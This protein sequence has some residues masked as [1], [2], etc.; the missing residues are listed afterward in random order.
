VLA[1]ASTGAEEY[2]ATGPGSTIS[3]LEAARDRLKKEAPGATK[4]LGKLDKRI[5]DE[6]A[7]S[8]PQPAR[9]PS[10]STPPAKKPEARPADQAVAAIV[11]NREGSLAVALGMQKASKVSDENVKGE[12]DRLL[13]G[14]NLSS[15]DLLKKFYIEEHLRYPNLDSKVLRQRARKNAELQRARMEVASKHISRLEAEENASEYGATAPQSEAEKARLTQAR[16]AFKKEFGDAQKSR[17]KKEPVE[18]KEATSSKVTAPAAE[19]IERARKILRSPEVTPLNQPLHGELQDQASIDAAHPQARDLMLTRLDQQ[20]EN[21]R[22]ARADRVAYAGKASSDGEVAR[23]NAEIADLRAFRSTSLAKAVADR[24]S[25]QQLEKELTAVKT[26]SERDP[27]ILS[28]LDP[29]I[30]GVLKSSYSSETPPYARGLGVLANMTADEARA[31]IARAKSA[32]ARSRLL[33]DRTSTYIM[34]SYGVDSEP[35]KAMRSLVEEYDGNLKKW[36]PNDGFPKQLKAESDGFRLFLR[37]K[38]REK[39]SRVQK[40]VDTDPGYLKKL[41]D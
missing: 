21:R 39:D 12:I 28:D 20:I 6:K 35:Y 18:T 36:S 33:R 16:A 4:L 32:D 41:L 34:G 38:I 13:K 30:R 10:P 9:E 40:L 15:E 17:P 31:A 29:K 5:R 24:K 11:K 19:S 14:E 27:E 2:G 1:D 23:L 26:L 8:A 37:K 3:A 22:K 25:A 7:K